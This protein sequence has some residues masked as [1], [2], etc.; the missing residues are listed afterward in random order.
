L[1]D[2]CQQLCGNRRRGVGC[3]SVRDVAVRNI[4][5]SAT[6]PTLPASVSDLTLI[7]DNAAVNFPATAV[8][9]RLERD[10]WWQLTDSGTL[11]V[12]GTA[13]FSAGTG[14]NI[15]LDNADDFAQS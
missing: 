13:T 14:N 6:F 1:A 12:G 3:G 2:F 4:S 11:T 10:R 15:T 9:R 7:F 8:Y 5:A